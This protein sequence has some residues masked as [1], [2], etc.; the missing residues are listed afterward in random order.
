MRTNKLLFVIGFLVT[1]ML[2]GTIATHADAVDQATTFT[3]S[4]P[5]QVP[6]RVLPAGTYLFKR[7]S[8]GDQNLVQIF[9]ASGTHV[10]ATVQTVRAQ[11]NEPVG[12][13][14]VVL[15]NPEDGGPVTL[16]KWFY[17]GRTTGCEFLY[18]GQVEALLAQSPSK[19][20]V[21]EEPFPVPVAIGYAFR[22]Y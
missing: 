3:F 16:V 2:F 8:A 19:T 4:Q 6:G 18:S 5:I 17:P 12:K 13:T 14:E 10:Y 20:T 15:A 1:A 22:V 21:A 9:N 11:R 7:P